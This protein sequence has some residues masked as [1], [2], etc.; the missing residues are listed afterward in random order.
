MGLLS[1]V[2]LHLTWRWTHTRNDLNVVT[3]T[4]LGCP[5]S[6]DV[7]NAFRL[8]LPQNTVKTTTDKVFLHHNKSQTFRQL[9]SKSNFNS[10]QLVDS[11]ENKKSI[12]LL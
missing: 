9:I 5:L 11:K 12:V 8:Y 4:T 1:R 7:V 3:V 10:V 2:P 6:R